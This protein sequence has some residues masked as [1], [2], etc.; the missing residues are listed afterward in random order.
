MEREK[1]L[2]TITQ[3]KAEGFSARLDIIPMTLFFFYLCCTI[4]LCYGL[5][6]SVYFTPILLGY[7][8]QQL[9]YHIFKGRP[10]I[11]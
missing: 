6:T 3:M 9:Q 5:F 1:K 7:S 10:D 8:R 4:V 11:Y 2:L